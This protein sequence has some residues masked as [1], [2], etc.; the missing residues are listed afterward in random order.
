MDEREWQSVHSL[1]LGLHLDGNC[2]EFAMAVSRGTGW[3]MFGVMDGS[4][5]R[6][7]VVKGNDGRFRDSRGVLSLKEIGEPF[8]LGYPVTLKA[9]NGADLRKVRLVSELG[10]S[11]AALMAEALWPEW[12]WK[13]KCF[14]NRSIAFLKELEVLCKKYSVW[15]RSPYPNM[16]IVID[17]R[18]GDE[19][20]CIEPACTGQYLFDR[21]LR[22][23]KPRR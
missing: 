2:Y 9:V 17:N 12:P 14:K 7:V 15:I 20:F 21:Y 16:K 18:H 4:V 11:R 22:S 3:P 1:C 6:H 19:G 13:E 10:I 23:N 8:R 5:V